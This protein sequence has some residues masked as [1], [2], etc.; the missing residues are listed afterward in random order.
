MFDIL[1]ICPPWATERRL[2]TGLSGISQFAKNIREI[3]RTCIL[4]TPY[5]KNPAR[6]LLCAI[7]G[8]GE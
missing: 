6:V 5:C 3:P 1:G 2:N 7:G 8:L 4:S